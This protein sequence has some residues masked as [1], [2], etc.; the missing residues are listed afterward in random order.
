MNNL[1]IERRVGS[2]VSCAFDDVS[3]VA[4]NTTRPCVQGKERRLS[5]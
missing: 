3:V 2:V 4:V 5:Y 1:D